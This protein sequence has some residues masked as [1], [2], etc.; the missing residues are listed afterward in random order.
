MRSPSPSNG[1]REYTQVQEELKPFA[2]K[3]YA[4]A[5]R[6]ERELKKPQDIEWAAADGKLF[7]LQA[8]PVT[9]LRTGNLDTYEWNDSLD[10]DFL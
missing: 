7:I 6:L 3:L 1:L 5:A 2:K 9:T 8:R 10:G 4:L